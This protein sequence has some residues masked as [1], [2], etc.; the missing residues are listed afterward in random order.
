MIPDEC[1]DWVGDVNCDGRLDFRDIN[2]FV[3]ALTNTGAYAAA[4][5]HCDVN[6]ADCNGDGS[7]GFG[8]INAFV[9]LLS[10]P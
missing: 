8:D 1:E 2:P 10:G 4:F 3:L 5:P 6:H 7:V 9:L